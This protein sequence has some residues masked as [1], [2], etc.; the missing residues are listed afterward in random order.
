MLGVP[1]LKHF[2]VVGVMTYLES[3]IHLI[4][5]IYHYISQF[6]DIVISLAGGLNNSS[7]N[8]YHDSTVDLIALIIHIEHGF[9]KVKLP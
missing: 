4:L 1:I 9:I 7:D 2:R 8:F 6:S 3:V 5:L